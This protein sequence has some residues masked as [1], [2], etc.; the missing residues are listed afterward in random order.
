MEQQLEYLKREAARETI[1]GLSKLSKKGEIL[2]L[3]FCFSNFILW[4]H[5][6][7]VNTLALCWSNRGLIPDRVKYLNTCSVVLG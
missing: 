2:F 3:N 1:E 7:M 4:I 6:V 5:G